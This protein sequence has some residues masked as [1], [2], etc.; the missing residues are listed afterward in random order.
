[1][2]NFLV[3]AVGSKRVVLFSPRDTLNLYL[4]GDKSA[5]L[6]IDHPDIA[7]YPLFQQAVRYECYLHPGD[8]L[9]IPALWFHNVL[10]ID[11][12]VAVNMFWRHLEPQFYDSKDVYGNKDPLH[13]QRA[14][15]IMEKALAALGELPDDYQD[16]YGRCLIARIQQRCLVKN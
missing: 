14:S 9:F 10:S 1:M 11:F 7:K 15:Q 5:I 13:A 16:F 6:D 3:Q 4:I 8:V 12:C 2:D